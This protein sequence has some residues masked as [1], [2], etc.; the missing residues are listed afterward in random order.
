MSNTYSKAEI[1]RAEKLVNRNATNSNVTSV[2]FP[3]KFQVGLDDENF[4]SELVAKGNIRLSE[5]SNPPTRPTDGQG[6]VLY[7]KNDGKL[8]YA[9]HEQAEKN[10]LS[11]G[12]LSSITS[13]GV[14]FDGT[15]LHV[16]TTGD[17]V[18]LASAGGALILGNK[19]G[20][21]L[22]FDENEIASKSDATTA[23][24]LYLQ[25]DGG[26]V[27]IG[28]LTE[29]DLGIGT[30][31]PSY[32]FHL[33]SDTASA[34]EIGVTQINN[35]TATDG[36]NVRMLR[37]RGT[38]ASPAIVQDGDALGVIT[39][40]GYDGTDYATNA[41]QIWA[42]ADGTPAEN[43]MPG[44]ILL[45]TTPAGS[46]SPVTR[47]T[48]KSDG[49]TGI[50]TTTPD[51]KLDVAGR[52]AISSE[53]ST[54]TVS[55]GVGVLYTKSGGSL[56]FKSGDVGETDLLASAGS[57]ANLIQTAA[58]ST[59]ANH[60][61]PFFANQ[62]GAQAIK[63]DGGLLYNPSTNLFTVFTTGNA[64]EFTPLRLYN[65]NSNTN[66]SVSARFD[67]VDTSNNSVDSGKIKVSKEQSFTSTSST[68]DSSMSFFTSLNGTL[69]E[70]MILKSDGKLGL[71][72]SVPA[73]NLH[74]SDTAGGNLIRL[75]TSNNVSNDPQFYMT[76]QSGDTT[77]GFALNY[78]NNTGDIRY[79][80]FFTSG[81]HIWRL[82][83]DTDASVG[84]EGM[85]LTHDGKLGIGNT[86][87][88]YELDVTGDINSSG[89]V[90]SNNY[91]LATKTGGD[92]AQIIL[93]NNTN[94]HTSGGA[95]SE[96]LFKDHGNNNLVKV[97]GSHDGSSDDTKGNFSVYVNNGSS[98][99]LRMSINSGGSSN[100]YG[101]VVTNS[102]ISATGMIAALGGIS[103]QGNI[104]LS[105][106]NKIAFN[107]DPTNTYIAAG[108]GATEDLE[109]H[110]DDDIKFKPDDDI[111]IYKGDVLYSTFDGSDYRL[112]M[113]RSTN[114]IV[115]P[116]QVIN[117]DSTSG[118]SAGIGMQFQLENTSGI[119][120][121]AASIYTKKSSNWSTAALTDA[122]L[123]FNV[124]QNGALSNKL[125]I[126]NTISSFTTNLTSNGL[127]TAESGI[128]SNGNITLSSQNKAV[129]GTT[130]TYIAANA[131]NPEDLE[132]HADQDMHLKPDND[133]LVYYGG[134]QYGTF[135]GSQYRLRLFRE[136]NANVYPLQLVNKEDAGTDSG[137]GMEFQLEN[138]SGTETTA[139]RITVDKASSWNSAVNTDARMV[140]DVVSDGTLSTILTLR[141][142][143]SVFNTPLTVSPGIITAGG[144]ITSAG[145][146]LLTGQ[147]KI[148]FGSDLVNTYIA[149]DANNP[150]NLEIH[151][152]ANI[153][154]RPDG[155][156]YHLAASNYFSEYLRHN[157]DTDT[158][159]RFTTDKIDL[160]AGNVSMITMT[161]DD[162][163][164]KVQVNVGQ[165]DVDFEVYYDSGIAS[166]IYGSDGSIY[167]YRPVTMFG[168]T[169]L[170]FSSSDSYI[171]AN[172]ENPEDLEIHA[173]QDLHLKPDNDV[174]IY[175][176]GTQYG[177]FDGSQYRLRLFRETNA[178]VYP[179][180]LVNKE[181]TGTSAGIGMEFQL[182][183]T[184]GTETTAARITV[185]KTSAWNSNANTDARMVFDV[186]SDGTLTTLLTVQNG[187]SVFNTPLTMPT[188][189]IT[190]GGG[191]TSLGN[192]TVSGQ[193]KITFDSADTYIAANT[194]NPEDLE[195]A[196]DQ[197]INMIPDNDVDIYY[198]ASR[199]A[200]F[201]GNNYRLRMLRETNAVVCPLQL[202]N[203]ED[204]GTSAGIGMQ[205]QLENTSGT[206]KTAGQIEVIKASGWNSGPNT[207]GEMIFKVV[208]NDSLGE[209]FRI[210]S[211][212]LL[213]TKGIASNDYLRASS[214]VYVGGNIY[215]YGDTNTKL[216]FGDDSITI[217]AGGVPFINIVEGGTDSLVINQ[218][219]GDIDLRVESDTL[220]YGFYLRGSDGRIGI[221]E[222]GP[223]GKLHIK[224]V[225]NGAA[226]N[227]A[228]DALVIE[229]VNGASKW[230]IGIDSDD[231]LVFAHNNRNPSENAGGYLLGSGNGS[232]VGTI[233]FTGQHRSV[234][235]SGSIS[236]YENRI[237][238][239][240]VSTGEYLN[241]EGE[242][243]TIDTALPKI[244]LSS[245][246]NQKTVY[247]VVSAITDPE[248][249]HQTYLQGVFGTVLPKKEDRVII[250]SLGE[251]SIWVSNLNGNLENGDYIT[252][253]EVSG[254][255]MKQD[256]DLLHN[257]TVAKITQDCNFDMEGE[258]PCEEFEHEGVTYRKA[259]VGCTYHCG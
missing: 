208:Q 157:G 206:E 213:A 10:L 214:D 156:I 21:H 17:R 136:T 205:F 74:I 56:Y 129:F 123:Y 81:N 182:E 32:R 42:Q 40:H 250:N 140:F 243:N 217:S 6:G 162:S 127:I 50:G 121:T 130:D 244:E 97:E 94:E 116:L 31:T 58:S 246:P 143:A 25:G 207:D 125:T 135:D 115:Y 73:A 164:D 90:R 221:G 160:Y 107:T 259:F 234:P 83:Q 169:Q 201:D 36:A 12:D 109:I 13:G 77:E 37:A 137:V 61:V 66:A 187:A 240:V 166:R 159:M 133:I 194:D 45:R 152:D 8:Y 29:A 15:S 174:T 44:R 247:G 54:P 92:P 180:Q 80:V 150:E 226:N 69:T 85:R 75:D 171:A 91:L 151:A 198:G 141:D 2:T 196:A 227:Y 112:R 24:T 175:Y 9:S 117:N 22:S 62:T 98:E 237:G 168:Q 7:V 211:S 186:V 38:K 11:G 110:A 46:A 235:A 47:V 248:K 70:Q 184:S 20:Q 165:A 96:I 189:L 122:A 254:Y 53:S 170:K 106:Q 89:A 28:S 256:D 93:R 1:D 163:Q 33:M 64:S 57:T 43:D 178:N 35:D 102:S 87:P 153:E 215:H 60:Y 118:T 67:L 148:A 212:Q 27:S 78:D 225:A 5:L 30:E 71:G 161:E 223:E 155:S 131:E 39:F 124:S 134:T 181:D 51:E 99:T 251:G 52:I 172:S 86:N 142:G 203:K 158:Y 167:F 224:Q 209:V 55:A 220:Q 210:N 195:I 76:G 257:F 105:G 232:F 139:A 241:H 228:G 49:N 242:S 138:T 249:E 190:A 144:G 48:I 173:D 128:L 100:F 219:G 199:Y 238:M 132:I 236:E 108:S 197:N 188:G 176:G 84:I 146:I 114:S 59:A 239:I 41:A 113:I 88:G 191:I 149:A 218:D 4:R 183:N 104:L 154:L 120:S 231:E 147:K 145:D 200:N 255:G 16:T 23:G 252:T 26:K 202:V 34:A 82:K 14:T 204:T 101:P 3:H 95:E 179:L 18:S 65:K 68:Q 19:A 253:S 72:T 216:T 258:Y 185:D 233:D 222:S 177:T 63:T 79:D 126:G 192:I 230:Y 103:A 229:N 119:E 193:N 111:H 245:S